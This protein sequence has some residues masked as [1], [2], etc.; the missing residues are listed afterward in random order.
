M[1]DTTKADQD[2]YIR[3]DAITDWALKTFHEQYKD[4]SI[5]KEDIFWYVYG[6]LHSPE[7]RT[8]FANDLKK[9]LPR[10]PYA[11]DFW[12]FSKAG[13]ELGEWHLNYETVEPWP[14]KEVF[15]GTIED[16]RV[17]KMRF[18]KNEHGKADKSVIRYNDYLSLTGIPLEVYEY[19]VNGR[20][21]IEWIMDRYEVTTDKASGIVNDPN[22]WADEH[23]EPRYIVDLLSRVVRVSM[24]SVR[25]VK[26]L[27][28]LAIQ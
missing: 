9:M 27:D 11:T 28:G 2:G 10:I 17:V 23:G 18:G 3:H 12:V 5:T 20:P 21:A 13:G 22:K 15:H 4:T 19:V 25:I 6:I 16:Y 26:R 8:R 24:E 1:D 7:Y 14:L